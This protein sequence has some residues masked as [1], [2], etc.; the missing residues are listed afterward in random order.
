MTAYP[1]M[2]GIPAA[3]HVTPGGAWHPGQIDGCPKC[4]PP[5]MRRVPGPHATGSRV[6]V[7]AWLRRDREFGLA[8]DVAVAA[9]GQY[10]GWV[11]YTPDG[12][13]WVTARPDGTWQAGDSADAEMRLAD[14]RR[15]PVRDRIDPDTVACG[16]TITYRHLSPVPELLTGRVEYA[17]RAAVH[18]T[19]AGR[20]YAVDWRRVTGHAP[21]PA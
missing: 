5:P 2:P 4:E 18:V 6:T 10:P 8:A 14:R 15:A 12:C 11:A 3:G 1:M 20:V 16:D 19:R 13:C 7:L 9:A 17:T 21:G